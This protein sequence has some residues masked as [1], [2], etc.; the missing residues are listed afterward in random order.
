M[1]SLLASRIAFVGGGKMTR[2]LADAI[3]NHQYPSQ[4]IVV[5]SLGQN[6]LMSLAADFKVTAAQNNSE[7]VRDANVVVMAVKPKDMQGVAREIA[8]NSTNKKA[9][10]YFNSSWHTY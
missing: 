7:A 2:I 8:K 10:D 9:V 6:K 5:S 1:L 3:I 4:Q